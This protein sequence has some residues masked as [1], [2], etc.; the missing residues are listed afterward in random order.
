MSAKAALAS[1]ASVA[2]KTPGANPPADRPGAPP[3]EGYRAES[4]ILVGTWAKSPPARRLCFRMA[5]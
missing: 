5:R 1:G 2:L 3:G 4:T